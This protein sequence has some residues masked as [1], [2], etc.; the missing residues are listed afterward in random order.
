MEYLSPLVNELYNEIYRTINSFNLNI[1]SSNREMVFIHQSSSNE[2]IFAVKPYDINPD[3][4]DAYL[5]E[6]YAIITFRPDNTGYVFCTISFSLTKNFLCPLFNIETVF[7]RIFNITLEQRAIQEKLLE[8][9]TESLIKIG[10]YT[11]INKNVKIK[12]STLVPDERIEGVSDI[13]KEN[14]SGIRVD[15][16]L[17]TID[18]RDY[19]VGGSM[20]VKAKERFDELKEAWDNL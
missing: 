19:H 5:P 13:I 1:L 8:N 4:H 20:Y 11:I 2:F 16:T 6:D 10:P 18:E 9:I 17:T 7:R 15:F 12:Y 3:D 14:L